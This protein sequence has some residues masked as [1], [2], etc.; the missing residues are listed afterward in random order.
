MLCNAR[1]ASGSSV[2]NLVCLCWFSLSFASLS[3][4]KWGVVVQRPWTH[5]I[6]KPDSQVY[7][8]YECNFCLLLGG[9]KYI[10]WHVKDY[11]FHTGKLKCSRREEQCSRTPKSKMFPQGKHSSFSYCLNDQLYEDNHQCLQTSLQETCLD[12]SMLNREYRNLKY[13]YILLQ[14]TYIRRHI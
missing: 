14:C 12:R 1:C 5:A 2:Q 6:I 9:I 11:W 8:V 4:W 7:Q 13:I 10:F 3:A